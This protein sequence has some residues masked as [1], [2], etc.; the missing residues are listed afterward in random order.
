MR[1][2]EYIRKPRYLTVLGDTPLITAKLSLTLNH[3]HTQK[4]DY[5][6]DHA[7]QN[8]HDMGAALNERG[9]LKAIVEAA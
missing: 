2:R 8:P 6:S 4:S 5:V 7:P 1:L 3:A 9:N